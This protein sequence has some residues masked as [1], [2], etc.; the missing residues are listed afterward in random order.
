MYLC[1]GKIFDV[2][3]LFHF[4]L[5]ICFLGRHGRIRGKTF[6]AVIFLVRFASS[7]SSIFEELS[8]NEV[9]SSPEMVSRNAICGFVISGDCPMALC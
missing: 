3:S 5:L 6:F 2:P 7:L 9:S 4:L 1:M 8:A